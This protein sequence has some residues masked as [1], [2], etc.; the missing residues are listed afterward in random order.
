MAKSRIP[1]RYKKK[2]TI[3]IKETIK[4]LAN[5]GF[6]LGFVG[7]SIDKWPRDKIAIITGPNPIVNN[8]ETSCKIPI[9]PKAINATF[10]HYKEYQNSVSKTKPDQIMEIIT[11]I[12]KEIETRRTIIIEW[13]T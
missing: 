5:K 12:T 1:K 3:S 13:K 4:K 10:P 8:K 2:T 11:L 6:W 7:I 9:E